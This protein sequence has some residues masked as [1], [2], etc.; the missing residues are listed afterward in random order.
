MIGN[1]GFNDDDDAYVTY[2]L[3]GNGILQP[4]SFMIQEHLRSGTLVEILS[5]WRP[6]SIPI[7]AAYPR[8]R[9]LRLTCAHSAIGHRNWSSV[10]ACGHQVRATGIVRRLALTRSLEH[11]A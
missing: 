3:S 11:T 4:P 10:S 9:P 8:S 7:W 6:R 5:S 2:G 1:F